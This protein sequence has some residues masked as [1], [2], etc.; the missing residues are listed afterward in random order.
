M[1]RAKITLSP[2]EMELV[3]NSDWILTKNN[4]LL[5]VRDLLNQLQERQMLYLLQF[6]LPIDYATNSPKISRGENYRGLPWLML[7][8]P[9]LFD[10]ENIFALRTMFWW[11]HF[12][13]ITLHLSGDSKKIFEEKIVNAYP[14]LSKNGFYCCVHEKQWEHHFEADNYS[15]V[16]QLKAPQFE[17]AI[18]TNSFVKLSHKISLEN[19]EDAP[20][21]LFGYFKQYMEMMRT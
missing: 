9:R 4:L 11:G 16:D 12:F 21:L 3:N 13:S 18:R 14:S 2:K 8:Y 6:P 1:N 15:R 7:D 5:K 17:N 20:D 10:H 19:W